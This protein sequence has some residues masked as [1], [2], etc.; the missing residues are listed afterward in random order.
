MREFLNL[1]SIL[2][3]T[4][5]TFQ[6]KLQSLRFYFIHALFHQ[7]LQMFQLFSG[8]EEKSVQSQV[9]EIEFTT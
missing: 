4:I 7:H 3:A 1:S 8:K 2:S 5:K 9:N 6:F